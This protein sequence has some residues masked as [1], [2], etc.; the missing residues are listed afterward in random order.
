MNVVWER[1]NILQDVC[2]RFGVSLLYSFGSR[3]QEVKHWLDGQLPE[4]SPGPSDVDFGAKAIE[5]LTWSVIDKVRLT[6]AM[7]DFLGVERVQLVSL[8]EVDPFLAAEVIRGERLF[9]REEHTANEYELYVLRRAGDLI[10]LERQRMALVLG[11]P[12]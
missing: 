7:E 2:C 11:E 4:L 8:A 6:I 3:Q 10:P 9:A 5:G 1:Y 12:L